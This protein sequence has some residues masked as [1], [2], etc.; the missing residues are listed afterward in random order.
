MIRAAAATRRLAATRS[1]APLYYNVSPTA[2]AVGSTAPFSTTAT[3]ETSIIP[4]RNLWDTIYSGTKGIISL[5]MSEESRQQFMEVVN[6]SV[7]NAEVRPSCHRKR[8]NAKE[9]LF[10]PWR[11]TQLLTLH[12]H[13]LINELSNR[14]SSR[15]DLEIC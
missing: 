4:Q 11:N 14:F 2:L 1:I 5:L 13:P 9:R 8:R 7:I 12:L 3:T 10:R 6:G 15:L